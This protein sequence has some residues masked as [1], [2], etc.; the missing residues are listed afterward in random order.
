MPGPGDGPAAAAVVEQRVDGLL[1]HPLLVVDDDLGR[2]EVEQPLEAVVAV[3][4]AAVEVVQVGGGEAAAVE[5]DHRAQLR[6]DH[7]DGLED[8]VLGLVVGVDER[9][10]DLQPLDRAALLLALGGL[11]LLLELLALGVEVDLLEQVAHRL[12][13][14]AA[15]EVLAEAERRAEA[16]LQLAEERLVGDDVLAAS[17]SWNISQTWRIRSAASSM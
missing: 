13:A 12:G 16:V 14:H 11:D 17:S 5:L 15:A 7:R 6:R 2:A 3:D 4:H 10:H 8:H 1:E 9:R